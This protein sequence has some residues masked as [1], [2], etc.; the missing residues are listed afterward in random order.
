M[1]IERFLPLRRFLRR[2][3][4]TPDE[5]FRSYLVRLGE[6]NGYTDEATLGQFVNLVK[7]ELGAAGGVERFASLIGLNAH[8]LCEL[9]GRTRVTSD[10][11][12]RPGQFARACFYRERY[13]A[14]CPACI[15]E[16]GVFKAVWNFR[17]VVICE[18]YRL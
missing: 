15:N 10:G 12:N 11:T 17:A 16:T 4:P 14:F 6:A 13:K 9:I 3:T 18:N 1:A 8:E 2:P 7:R 5:D